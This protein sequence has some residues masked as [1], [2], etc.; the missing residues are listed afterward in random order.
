MS[1]VEWKMEWAIGVDAIDTQ[2]QEW[3][4][5]LNDLY[6]A[7]AA[8]REHAVLAEVLDRLIR[9][10]GW[11]F[12]NEE[13]MMRQSGYPGFAAHQVEHNALTDQ[14]YS[15]EF[16]MQHGLDLGLAVELLTTLRDWITNHILR[17]DQR[18]ADFLNAAH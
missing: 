4:S 16:R 17:T 6:E 15:F 12:S 11:H 2:H 14:I 5:I 13:E 18:F 1:F 3:L 10:C 8:G 9:Y 7:M